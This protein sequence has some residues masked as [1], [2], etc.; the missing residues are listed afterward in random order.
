MTVFF[1]FVFLGLG[2]AAVYALLSSGIV[3]IYRGSGVLNFAQGSFALVGGLVFHEVRLSTHSVVLALVMA[4]VTGAVLGVVVQNPIM[5]LL[6]RAAPVTRVIATLAVL[7]IIES[8]AT[9]KLGATPIFEPG[10]LP[11]HTW[12]IGGVPVLSD[13]VELLGIA[14]VITVVLHVIQKRV[15]VALATRAAA[16]N[17]AAVANLGWSP[18]LLA[19]LNWGLGGALAGLAGALIA[20]LAGL[21]IDNMVLLIVPALAAALVGRLDSFLW[22]FAGAMGIG[23]GQSLI[24]R[25]VSQS[26]ASDAFPFLVIIGVLV[27]TGRGLPARHYLSQRLTRIG[28]GRIAVI[29]ALLAAVLVIAGLTTFLSVNVAIAITASVA[30]AVVLMSIV[31]LTGYAGQLSLAQY[32]MAGLGAYVSGR[33]VAAEHWPFWLAGI[34]ALA[35]AIPIGVIFALPALRTRGVTLAVITLGMGVAVESL[36]FSNPSYVGGATGTVIGNI[37][38]F[39]VNISPLLYP[40][41]YAVFVFVCFFVVA[42]VVARL[43]RSATG[44]RLIAIRANERAAASVGVSVVQTKTFAFMT[45]SAIA[46]LGGILIGF[47][48]QT[49]VYNTTYA[50]FDSF[51]AV[52]YTVIGG[53]GYIIGPALGSLLASGGV[54]TLLN[55]V[56]SSIDNYLGLIGAIALL[57][58][59]V[60]NP[61]GIASELQRLAALAARMLGGRLRPLRPGRPRPA[62]RIIAAPVGSRPVGRVAQKVLCVEDVTVRFGAVVAAESVSFDVHPS[63]IVALIGPNGAGKTTV[64]DAITGFVPMSSGRVIL[65]GSDLSHSSAARRA[66]AGVARS[67]QSLELFEDISVQENLQVSAESNSQGWWDD[68]RS[69]V[70]PRRH[71]LTAAANAAIEDF[72]L[73]D[74]LDASPADLPY[75]ERRLVGIARSV[76]LAPSVLLLDE[77]AAG[78]SSAESA[79]LGRLLRRLAGA[80]G[81]GI[82]LVE[83]DVDLVMGISDR[84]VVL[85]SGRPIAAGTP[86]AIRADPA[87][88]AA[89]LGESE[90]DGMAV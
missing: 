40:R 80:W 59:L 78:L 17:E 86:T 7:L 43:R 73:A 54:A 39:G 69:L 29:P 24:A 74:R 49:I 12:N 77:P 58:T 55:T 18:N 41:R 1:Q 20:P 70:W 19:T 34:A 46:A 8:A 83:H 21:L 45:A 3:L 32:A 36:I 84:I 85:D 64:I 90:P 57:L 28:T 76:A 50:P 81:M 65:G 51:L 82:L 44:R 4:A 16:E 37:Y 48:D 5:Y 56:L 30:V 89:Y 88:V 72:H 60:L 25:Y 38:L 71:H 27:L 2:L 33:L 53:L 62:R 14:A 67:W 35:A 22:S 15:P 63:E 75:G 68:L 47:V 10:Y 66:Q 79:D 61:D 31:V 87:V 6:R 9:L 11:V 42:L 52:A 13:R 23:I 26:G